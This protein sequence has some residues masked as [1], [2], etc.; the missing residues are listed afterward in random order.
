MIRVTGGRETS[1]KA[2]D[3]GDLGQGGSNG[4]VDKW[5]DLGYILEV[6]GDCII[7]QQMFTFPSAIGRMYFHSRL[8][9]FCSWPCDML[10]RQSRV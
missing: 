7:V 8:H 6:T 2:R 3:D 10:W 5:V 9:C 1:W 4:D